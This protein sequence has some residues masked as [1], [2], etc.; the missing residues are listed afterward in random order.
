MVS[1][2]EPGA[3]ILALAARTWC[4][5][6]RWSNATAAAGEQAARAGRSASLTR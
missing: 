3:A 1:G 2:S 4:R 6:C 5:H